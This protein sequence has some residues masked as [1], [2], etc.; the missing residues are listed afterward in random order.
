[1][2][3]TEL[4]EAN[5]T[6]RKRLDKAEATV[7]KMGALKQQY[8][9]LKSKLQSF[10]QSDPKLAKAAKARK[11]VPASIVARGVLRDSVATN[12]TEQ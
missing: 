2:R 11:S 7:A 6:L 10:E 1:M 12:Q 8:M 3:A 9:L 4:E 5:R